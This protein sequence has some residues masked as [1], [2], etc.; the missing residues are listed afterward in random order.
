MRSRLR[1][2]SLT[3]AATLMLMLVGASAASAQIRGAGATFPSKVYDRWAQSFAK[4]SEQQVAYRG[5]GSGDGIRQI[6]E[7]AVDFGGTDSPLS[8]EELA[9]RKLVQMPMLIG[10]I[11]PVINLHGIGPAKLL[12]SGEVLA[13]IMAGRIAK[14]NDA[15][16][17]A[18]NPGLVLPTRAIHRVVR[19]EKSGTTEG[20]TRYLAEVS[21]GFK[22]AVGIGQLPSWPGEVIKAEGNDGMVKALKATE[23]AIAYVS[24]DRVVKDGL[25]GVRLRNAANVVVSASEAGFRAAILDSDL[26]RKGDDV[27]SLMNRHSPD[28]WPITLTSYVL[29]DA[30]PADGK[31]AGPTLRFLYWCF[32]HG[33]ELTRGTGFAPLPVSLQARLAARFASVKAKD[34]Q[35]MQYATF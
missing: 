9:K 32:M 31:R 12:L 35:A 6:T 7:R 26:A 3:L 1:L 15:R 24:H 16:I 20:F 28:A 33:D 11:E 17:S 5:T 13:D 29:V 19:A 4:V 14:W 8:S 27:A 10:G 34:G 21:P 30:E 18:L 23:G 2:V 22:Q 25:A